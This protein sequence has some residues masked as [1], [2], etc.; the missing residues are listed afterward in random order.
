MKK[1]SKESTLKWTF[2]GRSEGEPSASRAY[3]KLE[4]NYRLS[5]IVS[6]FCERHSIDRIGSS[7]HILKIN[8]IE[9]VDKKDELTL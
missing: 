4:R 6:I 1:W 9:K 7:M 5:T 2:D 3:K 8:E